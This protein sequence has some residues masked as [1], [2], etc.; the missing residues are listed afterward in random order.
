[1]VMFLLKDSSFDN[2]RTF[3]QDQLHLRELDPGMLGVSDSKLNSISLDFRSTTMKLSCGV[4]TQNEKKLIVMRYEFQKQTN[5]AI[6][7]ICTISVL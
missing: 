3:Y 5:N 6:N 1:M 2:I 7:C 4:A